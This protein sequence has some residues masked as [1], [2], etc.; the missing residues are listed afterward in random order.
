ML[1]KFASLA[2]IN[3]LTALMSFFSTWLIIHKSGLE[4]VGLFAYWNAL[5]AMISLIVYLLPPNFSIIYLQEKENNHFGQML[6]SHYVYISL[7]FVCL[8]FAGFYFSLLYFLVVCF[9]LCAVWLNYIDIVSQAG[10]RLHAYFVLKFFS[11]SGIVIVLALLEKLTIQTLFLIY[12]ISNFFTIS[13]YFIVHRSSAD[14]KTVSLSR[15]LSYMKT[16]YR[17]FKGYYLDIIAKR[18]KDSGLILMIGALVSPS[19]LGIFSIFQKCASFVVGN[20]RILESL[21]LSKA[22]FLQYKTLSKNIPSLLGT[23]GF[24]GIFSLSVMFLYSSNAQIPWVELF[25]YSLFVFPAARVIFIRNSL[26]MHY[27]T[28][29]LNRY[30]SLFILIFITVFM[31]MLGHDPLLAICLA[32]ALSE[33]IAYL[34]L[35]KYQERFSA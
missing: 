34:Y 28:G 23:I 12:I 5:V 29:V 31:L 25:V 4:L 19:V 21:L 6:F 32:Y 33:T 2:G 3:T 16:H 24:G 22:N 35:K 14:R 13:L 20:I 27:Q 18:L 15:Y 30:N 1:T 7:V 26:L 9:A 8:A 11:A 17:T 10:N